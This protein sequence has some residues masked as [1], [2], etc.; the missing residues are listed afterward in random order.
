MTNSQPVR[1]TCI[2]KPLSFQTQPDP[3]H[4]MAEATAIIGTASAVLQIA[5]S[6]VKTSN[7][8]YDIITTI[9]NAPKEIVRLNSDIQ[10]L[11]R[12]MKNLELSLESSDTCRIVD[13]DEEFRRSMHD[14]KDL[15]QSC[16]HTC[17]EITK[18]LRP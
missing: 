2:V 4:T 8:L 6:A 13:Q 9:K 18:R 11:N 7:Q 16:N 17:V 3:N 14:L 1:Q 12:L 15:I 5:G 10:A